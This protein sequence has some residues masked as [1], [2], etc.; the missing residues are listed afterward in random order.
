MPLQILLI[1]G[2]CLNENDHPDIIEES[3]TTLSQLFLF[4]FL[5][6]LCYMYLANFMSRHEVGLVLFTR[7]NCMTALRLQC[8]EWNLGYVYKSTEWVPS[9]IIVADRIEIVSWKFKLSSQSAVCSCQVPFLSHFIRSG[10]HPNSSVLL[11][12]PQLL[13]FYF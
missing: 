7:E 1:Y 10:N 6:G 4:W 3:L 9:R 5:L 8:K 2:I 11:S 12:V 13:M